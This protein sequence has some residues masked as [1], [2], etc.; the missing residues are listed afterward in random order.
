VQRPRTETGRQDTATGPPPAQ[1]AGT[2]APHNM[3]PFALSARVLAADDLGP[4]TGPA[5]AP[6]SCLHDEVVLVET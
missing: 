2:P 6:S 4:S 3:P 5:D 1:S